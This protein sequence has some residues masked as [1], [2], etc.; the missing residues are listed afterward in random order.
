M[1]VFLTLPYY[2]ICEMMVV[3]PMLMKF[4]MLKLDILLEIMVLSLYFYHVPLLF[5]DHVK[6]GVTICVT[7]CDVQ[8]D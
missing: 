4:D 1:H 8:L 5:Y 7:P 2:F 3:Y 6:V